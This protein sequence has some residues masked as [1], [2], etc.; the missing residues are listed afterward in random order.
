ML[1]FPDEGWIAIQVAAQV[2]RQ[3]LRLNVWNQAKRN[4]LAQKWMYQF[5]LLALLVGHQHHLAR[6]IRQPY[7][8][9]TLNDKIPCRELTAVDKTKGLTRNKRIEGLGI[10]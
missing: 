3:Q 8:A 7:S 10:G 5:V 4:L 9:A 2:P 6:L 1:L